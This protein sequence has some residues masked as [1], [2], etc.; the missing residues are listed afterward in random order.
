MISMIQNLHIGNALRVFLQPPMGSLVWRVLRKGADTF[1]GADDPDAIVAYEGDEKSFV[2]SENLLNEVLLFY[3]PYYTVDN[4]T[5]TAGATASGTPTSDYEDYSTD[6]IS[7]LR[8]RLE[9]AL[10]VECDR[11]NFQPEHGYIQVFTAAPSLERDL[12][13][14]LVTIHL[15]NEEPGERA[16]GEMISTD[17][18][19]SIGYEWNDAEGWLSNVALTII[20][21]SL[22]SD[23]RM[24]LRKALRRIIVANL[25][26]LSGH[27][28][29]Q[30]S[31]SQS[32]VDA[33]NGEYPA[34]IYQ[35][36]CNFTCI[37]P[38]RVGGPVDAITTI[39]TRSNIN[40]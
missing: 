31:L 9:A 33:V 15:E 36:M 22:N 10:K 19:D 1:T 6:V 18:F 39:I 24:E 35:V 34:P 38:V 2:D 32:D 5:W 3:K 37:A 30:V 28:I 11:G 12:R 4:V 16:I 14:P 27:G 13:L 40:G 21:W 17:K 25:E 7:I 23:E 29:E 20:G 8:D 26:V